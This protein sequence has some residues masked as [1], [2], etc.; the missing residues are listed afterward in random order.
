MNFKMRAVATVAAM[1]CAP[2]QLWQ[3]KTP[4]Y[5]LCQEYFLAMLLLGLGRHEQQDRP[6]L[7]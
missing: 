1:A 6:E 2:P 3:P 7:P 5:T 4:D